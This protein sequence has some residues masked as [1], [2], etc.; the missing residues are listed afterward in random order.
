[1]V[2][3]MSS[4]GVDVFTTLA[5]AAGALSGAKHGGASAAVIHML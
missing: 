1:M 3:H 4:S 2:R 5:A